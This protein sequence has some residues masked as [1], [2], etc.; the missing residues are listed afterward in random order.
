MNKPQGPATQP[1]AYHQSAEAVSSIEQ[2]VNIGFRKKKKNYQVKMRKQLLLFTLIIKQTF[3]L[4]YFLK[5]WVSPRRQRVPNQSRKTAVSCK[6]KRTSCVWRYNGI[7]KP[8]CTV[9]TLWGLLQLQL[10]FS[11]FFQNV[12]NESSD[13]TGFGLFRMDYCPSNTVC[14]GNTICLDRVR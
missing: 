11:A 8:V 2:N 1:T 4:Y 13:I 3:Q 9:F 12:L 6:G 7:F 10:L 14:C 5:F